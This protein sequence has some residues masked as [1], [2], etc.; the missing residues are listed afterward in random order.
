MINQKNTK[1]Y[2]WYMSKVLFSWK[3][4]EKK[5]GA[6]IFGQMF[7]YGREYLDLFG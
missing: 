2:F 1:E 6:E 4:A 3:L 5:T 7:I